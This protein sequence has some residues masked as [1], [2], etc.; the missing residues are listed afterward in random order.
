MNATGNVKK[1][2]GS[3][4]VQIFGGRLKDWAEE[5]QR[6]PG[7]LV[8]IS[9]K[10]PRIIELMAR[11]GY[12]SENVLSR[13]IAEQALPF[14]KH[15]NTSFIV[16]DDA[17]TYGTTFSRIFKL[18]E[19]VQGDCSKNER[20]VG[21]PFAVG[22][23]ASTR[24]RELVT[25]HFMDIDSD[26]IAPLVNNEM[27]AFRLLGKPYDIEHPMIT[28]AGDFTD[29]YKLETALEQITELLGG[30]KAAI[31]TPVP[32]ATGIIPIR[33]WTI[34][35]PTNFCTNPYQYVDFA[36]LRIYLNVERNQ[37]LVTAIRPLSISRSDFE[38]F[39]K[40]LPVPLD[41][42][43]NDVFRIVNIENDNRMGTASC[44]S[45]AMW[46]NFLSSML[47]LREVKTSFIETF[48]NIIPQTQIHGPRREDLQYLVG[49]SLSI[50]AE[51]C[52][53]QFLECTELYSTSATC[54][55]FN[56]ASEVVDDRIPPQ[57]DECY[58]KKFSSFIDNAQ[59]V[60]D[61][62]RAIF[63][64]Q[65]TAIELPSRT[66]KSDDDGSRLE[67]GITYKKIRQTVMDKFPDA[68]EI[69]IHR[70]LDKLID[71]GAIVPR[72]LN[73]AV[74]SE[75]AVWVRVFRVGE[76]TVP[77]IAQT[78]RLLFETLSEKLHQSDVPRIV[79]EKFC[80]LALCVATD[81]SDLQSLQSLNISKTFH[82]YGAR[83]ALKVGQRQEFLADW[84]VNQK[85]ISRGYN[86]F[87]TG[88]DG[89][90]NLMQDIE[91]IYPKRECHWDK[92]VKQGIEDLATLVAAIHNN[93]KGSILV[94][95]TSVASEQEL[96]R[97]LEAE[98]ELWLHDRTVSIYQAL[99]EFGR[100]IKKI[101]ENTLTDKELKE[102]LIKI[103]KI[104]S[105]TANFTA[106]VRVKIKLFDER[107]EIYK[108]ID[109]LVA[110]DTLMARCWDRIS[111]TLYGRANSEKLSPG[112]QEIR[113]T[114][115]I[116][117]ITNRI[118]RELLILTGFQSSHSMG[119]EKS[120]EHL[121]ITLN[122]KEQ[123]DYVTRTMFATIDSK[124]DIAT[125]IINAKSQPLNDL[126]EAFPIIRELILEIA[127]RC[128]RVLQTH[129]T[130]FHNEQVQLLEPPRYIVMWD[131]KNSTA[132]ESRDTIE[133]VIINANRRI[134]E[135]LK[136][137][138][139]NFDADSKDDGNGLICETFADVLA[140]FQILN[141]VFGKTPFRVG[142]DVN[143]QGRLNYY[144]QSMKLGGRAFEY[145]ARV[146]S[147]FKEVNSESTR[148]TGGSIPTEPDTGYII[149]SEFAK[150]YAQQEGTWP[151][152][153]T[154]RVTELEGE[155]KAR[156][157]ASLPVSLAIIQL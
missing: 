132:L 98:L 94:A 86:T 19:Q 35:L 15:N 36:K 49:P 57:Y 119:L 89:N 135:T 22:K 3:R 142:C 97:A 20:P 115:R 151:T 32:S 141:E 43:W 34:L 133:P 5:L 7:T 18:T 80:T 157:S 93:L 16:V 66:D 67:F 53:T 84:A 139:M 88:E 120:L 59:E 55:L 128:E 105:K 156:V 23:N 81:D 100:L 14:L 62:L 10:G 54:S 39:G 107:Q 146:A 27:L 44:C 31:D 47:L 108:K 52:I 51:L 45:L 63:Y 9:R 37:L 61:V 149:V 124:S 56:H 140:I 117:H 46:A 125:L 137:R 147:F 4:L 150:R 28:W 118:L 25:K 21:I 17:M 114:L 30:Q 64:S 130:D 143:L 85:I 11:E 122:N 65:H 110:S 131:I 76:G 92:R 112:L 103:D 153:R 6:Q 138:A 79:F 41:G 38:Y 134:K 40:T 77:Q 155:Y 8:A 96:H 1:V 42:L 123:V 113:S 106:Q 69:D 68:T 91:L 102:N 148:W 70:C 60:E 72:Y 78:V 83:P 50:Q 71:N 109:T 95:L 111:T 87:D 2:L 152:N 24:H 29:T 144:S 101:N 104:F 90:Y 26:Q 136:D 99:A 129:G 13:V 154:H 145:A 48:E 126:N 82:L 74:S 73:M 116:V 121:L 33:R 75:S 58:K 12:L 127:N